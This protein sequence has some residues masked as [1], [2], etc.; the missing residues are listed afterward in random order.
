VEL[1]LQRRVLGHTLPPHPAPTPTPPPPPPPPL[2]PAAAAPTGN[3]GADRSPHQH[4]KGG[5]DDVTSSLA[6]EWLHQ[7]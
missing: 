7:H 6:F 2:P 3:Q 1:L 4:T 5:G